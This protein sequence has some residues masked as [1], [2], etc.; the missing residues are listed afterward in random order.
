MAKAKIRFLME[1]FK[2]PIIATEIGRLETMQEERGQQN[3]SFYTRDR[4]RYI[5]FNIGREKSTQTCFL[6]ISAQSSGYKN[7][8]FKFHITNYLKKNKQS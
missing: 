3:L 6:N 1:I 5:I 8:I 2:S 7:K 4:N